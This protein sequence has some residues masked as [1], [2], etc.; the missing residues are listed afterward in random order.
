LALSITTTRLLPPWQI[1]LAVLL[2]LLLAPLVAV[3]ARAARS[4]LQLFIIEP[5][6]E[7]H[8]GP[9]RGFPVTQVVARG[10][11][12][13]VLYRRTDWFKVRT[14]HG[15]EGWASARELSHAIL[16][17]GSLFGVN[18]G[19]RAG[20]RT[21]HWEGGIMAGAYAG[22][23]LV[24][25]FGS[26]SINDNLKVEFD[27]SQYLGSISDGY[28]A[29]V[30]LAHVFLPDWPISPFVTLGTG[31]ERVEPK[32]TLVQPV[33]RDDQ[34]GYYGGGLRIYLTRR[35]FLR[36]EYRQDVVFTKTNTNEVNAE[37]R[38]GF[39]FFY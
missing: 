12:L 20:F 26:L 27:L 9:G 16:A 33:D 17:D 21:H 11:S 22:A 4:P 30:G 28:L 1:K 6:L 19:D 36:A 31:F 38:A 25:A 3:P 15:I 34:I 8:T 10:E 37:W 14:E 13:D 5:Y 29:D 18:Q 2:A 7:L 39:A 23:T 24:S 35:F 32:A